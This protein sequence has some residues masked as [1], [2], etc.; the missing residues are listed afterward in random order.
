[1][2]FLDAKTWCY[3]GPI[4]PAQASLG[5]RQGRKEHVE[6]KH[7]AG[8]AGQMAAAP[9]PEG[10]LRHLCRQVTSRGERDCADGS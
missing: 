4:C 3:P 2:S 1:M 8:P 9:P 5:T 6:A 7:N 10:H